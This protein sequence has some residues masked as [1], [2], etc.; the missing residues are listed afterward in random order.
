MEAMLG[1]EPTN[2]SAKSQVDESNRDDWGRNGA[3]SRANR[4]ERDECA[5]E[6]TRPALGRNLWTGARGEQLLIQKIRDRERKHKSVRRG[7]DGVTEETDR[8]VDNVSGGLWTAKTRL[9]SGPMED[10]IVNTLALL[11]FFVLIF[12][13]GENCYGEDDQW[14]GR[15]PEVTVVARR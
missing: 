11:G 13:V 9:S 1:I 8:L 12:W 10:K 6:R 5:R 7:Q 2:T 15:Q 3:E 4:P 14:L